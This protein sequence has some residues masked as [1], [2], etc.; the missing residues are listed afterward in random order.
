MIDIQYLLFLQHLREITGGIFNGFFLFITDLGWSVLPVLIACFLYWSVSKSTGR[1]IFTTINLAD[2]TSNFIKVTVCAYR[3]WVRSADIHPVEQARATATGYSFPSG[4][5]TVGTSLWG[6]IGITWKN[7]RIIR[8]LA[9]LIILLIGF[10]R[11]YL[12]VHTPQDVLVALMVASF[13]LWASQKLLAWID[14]DRSRLRWM[15][16]GAIILAAV[17][18]LY[19]NLKSYPMDYVNGELLVDPK[20][21]ALDGLGVGGNLLGFGVGFYLEQKYVNFSTDGIS[22]EARIVRFLTGALIVLVFFYLSSPLLKLCMP[23]GA[24]KLIGGFLNYLY[25]LFLHPYWFQKH[26]KK[27]SAE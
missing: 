18:A 15:L 10:S 5:T 1:Y 3:P 25:I 19:A 22:M 16:W 7:N 2:Y 9:V 17:M 11:N 6:G 21:L 26:E 23:A 14:A 4:H 20:K 13:W 24:A 27:G 8:R 12:G